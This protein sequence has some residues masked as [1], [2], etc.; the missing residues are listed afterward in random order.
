MFDDSEIRPVGLED[1]AAFEA[2]MVFGADSEEVGD[3]TIVLPGDQCAGQAVIP[4]GKQPGWL[5]KTLGHFKLLRLIAEGSMGIVIQAM[6]VNLHRIVAL[7]VLRKRIVG[8]DDR[9]RVDQFLREARA[10]AR[11]DHP[12]VVRIYEINEH[13]GWWYI[14]MEMVEGGSVKQIIK[15]AGGMPP[16]RAC[17]V[18]ADAAVAL[19]AGHS[20][21]IIHRDVKPGNLM[22]TRGG[23]CKLTDFGLV[24]LYDPNDPFDFTTGPVGTP[25][26]VAPEVIRD[27]RS[28][29]ASDV[30]S[31]GGTLYYALT[32]HPP[33]VGAKVSRILNQHLDGPPPELSKYIPDCPQSLNKLVHWAMAKDPAQRPVAA[34]FASALRS[35]AIDWRGGDSAAA[36]GSGSGSSV[37]GHPSLAGGSPATSGSGTL[38]TVAART[39]RSPRTWITIGCAVVALLGVLVLWML[40]G[41]KGPDGGPVDTRATD[42][43]GRFPESPPTYGVLAPGAVS[44]PGLPTPPAPS[45]SWVGKRDTTGLRFVA[46]KRGRYF[47][48]IEHPVAQLIRSDDFV[49]YKSFEAARSDGK[50]P[51]Q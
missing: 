32:G 14:A 2:S 10:A 41:P 29:S 6:D 39:A 3:E 1:E 13:G 7:K 25:Q 8:F 27:H 42:I 5:G 38:A 16:G 44:A 50:I 12:N 4:E 31:L 18:I 51:I 20:L 19:A 35:E 17:P 47:Y 43:T 34:D 30:Y 15:A 36:L 40:F 23:H 28:A 46:S 26:F 24:R 11:L 22:V 9:Q 49:G 48:P 33:Y 21:G 37:F 45:F